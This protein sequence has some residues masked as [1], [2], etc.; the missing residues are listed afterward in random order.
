MTW[1]NAALEARVV[2]YKDQIPCKN[3]FI[4][5]KTPGSDQKENFC[6]IGPGVAERPDQHIHIAEP[7]GF[8]VGAARQPKGCVNSQHS[9]ETA[10][11][12][13]VHEGEWKFTW[14]HDSSDGAA[15]LGP[16]DAI[17]IPVNVFR[18]FEYV[19]EGKGYLF[20]VLG[21]DDPGFVTWAPYVFEEAKNYGMIL[22]ED[23]SLI[24]TT[25]GETIPEGKKEAKATRVEDLK[26]FRRMSRDEMLEC[27][28]LAKDMVPQSETELTKHSKG[29]KE[30]AVIGVENSDEGIRAG[31]MNWSHDYQVRRW[32]LS[33]GGSIPAHKRFEPEV[34]FVH[35]GELT[36]TGEF[37]QVTIMQGDTMT[38]PVDMIRSF[39]NN[40]SQESVIYVTRRDDK[41]KAPEWSK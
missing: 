20:C 21:Q 36:I 7:H 29:L 30:V 2:R 4:D 33:A 13:I 10:E 32:N 35:E 39:E 5:T 16:G 18:G 12:F 15:V 9:H 41:P 3:A 25:L 37:G 8:N 22:L 19:G 27:V 23:S 34:L 40:G 38:V 14:G 17:S 28:L 6:L 26:N 31:K 24:D 11:M 1:D